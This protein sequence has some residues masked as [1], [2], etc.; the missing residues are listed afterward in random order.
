MVLRQLAGII[1]FSNLIGWKKFYKWLFRYSFRTLPSAAGAIGMGCI[2][3]PNHPVYEITTRCNL[4]CIHCHTNGGEGKILNFGN[5]LATDEAKKLIEELAKVKDFRMLVYSGGEPLV[6]KDIFDLLNYSKKAG[7]INVL[8]TNATLIE[9]DTAKQLKKAG[10]VCV[11][12][13]LDSS[14]PEVHNK[15]RQNNKAFELA[16]RGIDAI[17]KAGILLQINTTAME[18]NFK[19]LKEIIK[20]TD[21]LGA[22]IMLMYQLVP[23]GRGCAVKDATLNLN[24]NEKLIKYLSAAQKDVPFIVETVASPQYWPYLMEKKGINNNFYLRFAEKVFHGC[25]AGSGLVYI[26]SNGDVWPC[27][28][29]EISAGNVRQKPFNEIW[30]KSEIFLNLRNRANL[31]KGGCGN[32]RYINVCGGCRGRALVLAGDYMGEDKLC[33]IKK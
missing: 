31:L 27:P 17:K 19:N 13:S 5:E 11:A 14:I 10:V 20:L 3:F 16:M 12:V 18:Y 21:T 9:Y 33:F 30:Y 24:T 32:C 8:A 6:R 25:S 22:A 29:L 2:G 4:K 28:F 15:I 1:Y 23:V 7:F 26:K